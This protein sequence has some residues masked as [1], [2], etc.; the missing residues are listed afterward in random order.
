V[1]PAIDFRK[2]GI[3]INLIAGLF[4][5]LHLPRS[6]LFL[7]GSITIAKKWIALVWRKRARRVLNL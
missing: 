5:T 2:R 6:N 1:Q 4:G 7:L 3:V